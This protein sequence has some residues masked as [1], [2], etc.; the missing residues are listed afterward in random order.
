MANPNKW[1]ACGGAFECG[2]STFLWISKSTIH[3]DESRNC[4]QQRGISADWHIGT[5]QLSMHMNE[6]QGGK[7]QKMPGQSLN[8]HP[9]LIKCL[10]LHWEFVFASLRIVTVSLSLCLSIWLSSVHYIENVFE[11][12]GYKRAQM[13]R[14]L[15]I[16]Q[17]ERTG[18][19]CLGR[20]ISCL[21]QFML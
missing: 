10:L 20:S 3:V 14:S 13:S 2:N 11:V 1:W 6:H 12:R 16:P 9:K 15:C 17:L 19:P 5:G 18:T 21:K 4:S 8:L 7:D